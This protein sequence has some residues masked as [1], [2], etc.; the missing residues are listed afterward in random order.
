MANSAGQEASDLTQQLVRRALEPRRHGHG[1]IAVR[2][3]RA[4]GLTIVHHYT[5]EWNGRAVELP[6]AQLRSRG[7]R[8]HL[9]WRRANG[10]WVAY[11]GEGESPFAGTLDACLREIRHDPWGC[12]WG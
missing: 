7:N 2:R 9:Y 8:L 5:S 1:R 11:E 6:V 10:R 4:T 3:S 12:F